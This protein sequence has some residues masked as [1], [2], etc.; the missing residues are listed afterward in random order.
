MTGLATACSKQE[1]PSDAEAAELVFK[2][3]NIYTVDAALPA[4]TSLAVR[5]G[6]IVALGSDQDTAALIGP[7]T[8]VVDLQGKLCCRPFTTRTPIRSGA[9]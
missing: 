7:Q 4:A 5:D 1:P 8:Q 6:R 9:A 2:N 3:A